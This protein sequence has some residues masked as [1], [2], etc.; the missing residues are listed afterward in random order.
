MT[1]SRDSVFQEN[2]ET[3]KQRKKNTKIHASLK[4]KTKLNNKNKENINLDRIQALGML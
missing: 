4:L 3:K 1:I 2:K